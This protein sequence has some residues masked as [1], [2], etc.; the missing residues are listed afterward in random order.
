MNWRLTSIFIPFLI[1]RSG[2]VAHYIREA[3]AFVH[4]LAQLS[5]I[6]FH[7]FF[8]LI[9]RHNSYRPYRN[10]FNPVVRT[11]VEYEPLSEAPRGLLLKQKTVT[12]LVAL[13]RIPPPKDSMKR[14]V[15]NH[16]LKR[17]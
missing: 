17:A 13:H 7:P 6:A 14:Y 12:L 10:S 1:I 9:R 5:F 11:A 4:S 2:L 16:R 8:E 3:K 15:E